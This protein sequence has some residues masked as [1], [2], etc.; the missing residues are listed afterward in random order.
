MNYQE[1]VALNVNERLD[2]FLSSL[3]STNKTPGYFVNWEKVEKGGRRFEL[4]LNTL[5]YL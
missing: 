4:E 1:Y 2:V 3:S 5:N